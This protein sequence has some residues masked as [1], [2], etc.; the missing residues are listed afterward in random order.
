MKHKIEVKSWKYEQI[1]NDKNPFMFLIDIG[2]DKYNLF[3]IIEIKDASSERSHS[4]I[5]KSI[6]YKDEG[7]KDFYV[8][9]SLGEKA[10]FKD[11]CIVSAI[12]QSLGQ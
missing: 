11:G 3:D 2:K 12:S 5:V 9:L 8:L 4:R 10:D 7:M 1:S 6:C